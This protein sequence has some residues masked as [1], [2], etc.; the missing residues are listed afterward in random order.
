MNRQLIIFVKE[1][2][3][4]AVKTRLG[5]EIGMAEAA[6][7]YRGMIADLCR[8]LARDPRWAVSFAVS[9]DSFQLKD[10]LCTPQGPGD[11]G[12]RMGRAFHQSPPGPVVIVGSDI[13]ALR[14]SH[15]WSAFQALGRSEA[16]FGPS[17]DG[18]YWL[19]GLGRRR[20]APRLFDGVRWSSGN[21]LA[22][23]LENLRGRSV[24]LLDPLNDIDTID[25]WRAWQLSKRA[26]GAWT[27]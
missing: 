6:R 8:R 17:L 1:P 14:P 16:V 19:I 13:P 18:G 9:P 15:I 22:D 21:E 4:G 12:Q 25:D 26:R 27:V 5:A 24:E 20:P 3:V 7:I 23:T 10:F 2:R 11:L